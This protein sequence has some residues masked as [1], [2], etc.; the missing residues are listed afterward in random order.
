MPHDPLE[1]A[2]ALQRAPKP[3]FLSLIQNLKE[4]ADFRKQPPLHLT[5]RPVQVKELFAKDEFRGR[6]QALSVLIHGGLIA[7][8]L[9]LGTNPRVQTA[10]KKSIT[11]I[12]P[13]ISPYT[14]ALQ[15]RKQPMGGGG[16]GGD[17]SPLP[18]SPGKLPRAALKQF[19]PPV[20]VANNPGPRLVMEPTIIADPS[21]PLPHVDL[22][23]Y[24][25]PFAK[26]GPPSNGQGSGGGIGSGKGGGV[27]SGDGPGV[28][29][30]RNGGFGGGAIRAGGGGVSMPIPIFK[31]E[32]EYS[33]EARKAKYQGA[34]LLAIVV[35]AS[36]KTTDVR[37]LRSL[38]MGLDEKAVEAVMK[39][40]F[41]PGRKDGHEVP[42]IA[43]VEVSFRLL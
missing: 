19:T 27:G 24:G 34:V 10:V 4:L 33:E 42:V 32:P 13:D 39:W 29:P 36:G 26:A 18:A 1:Q 14:P 21:T 41:R 40:R 31:V 6:S 35:D 30:G 17:N 22:P 12:A 11:L 28:G 9:F 20:A 15:T 25:D 5:S 37:V 16:G 7:A 43:N 3:W 23:N 2:F 38:G 8:A